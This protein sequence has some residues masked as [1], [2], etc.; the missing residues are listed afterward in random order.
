MSKK[1]TISALVGLMSAGAIATSSAGTPLDSSTIANDDPFISGSISFGYDSSYIFRGVDFG[2]DAPWAGIDFNAAI[3]DNLGVNFGA[4]YINPTSGGVDNDE[5]DLYAF[6]TTSIGDLDVAV[7]GTA[8]FFT[9]SDT[10]TEELGVILGYALGPIDLGAVY[11]YDF[12]TQGSYFEIN[13]GTSFEITDSL[14]L[15]F[16]TGISYGDDYFGVSG[17][18]HTYVSLAVPIALT[19]TL[20][21]TPY[22][23]QSFSIDALEDL[24]QDDHL[25]GGAAF[26]VEF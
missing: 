12:G 2:Q 1:K 23:A 3:T 14:A 9:E 4:W 22:I 13:A 10:D 7:G 25:Y 24:G 15:E 20:T 21:L 6:L 8:F 11:H 19:D 18:N 16:T 5:L 17:F 26:T